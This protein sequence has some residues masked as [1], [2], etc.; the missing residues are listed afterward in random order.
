MWSKLL[1]NFERQPKKLAVIRF[2]IE[3]G[4]GIRNGNICCNDLRISVVEIARAAKVDRRTVMYTIRDVEKSRELNIVFKHLRSAGPSLK[5]VAPY[6]GF[7]VLEITPTNPK[8]PGILA[9]V[10]GVLADMGVTVRQ[11]L[12]DDPELHPQPK[13]TLIV[14]GEIPSEAISQ[15]LKIR[16]VARITMY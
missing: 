10:A 16:G 4:L 12:V 14:E 11:A 3:N 8:A 13:L 15:I 7:R 2:L 9:K 6:L 1:K 5:E